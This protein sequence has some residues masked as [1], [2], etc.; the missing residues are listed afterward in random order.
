[1]RV[2]LYGVSI[3]SKTGAETD[4]P[5]PDELHVK[6]DKRDDDGLLVTTKNSDCLASPKSDRFSFIVSILPKHVKVI[7]Q[8]MS[9][10]KPSSVRALPYTV[11]QYETS[12]N[13]HEIFD[14]KQRRRY[15]QLLICILEG[16]YQDS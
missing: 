13:Q 3:I 9:P 16:H 6:S 10:K 14:T 15:V 12:P 7:W 2:V 8:W 11:R 4:Q 1:M 5:P